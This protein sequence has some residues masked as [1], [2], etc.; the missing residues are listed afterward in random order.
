MNVPFPSIDWG[1]LSS[2]LVPALLFS[3]RAADLSLATLRTLAVIRGRSGLAW[4][5]GF[6]ESVFFLLGAAGLLATL[7]NPLNLLAYGAGFA[8]GNVIGLSLEGRLLPSHAL[9]RIYSPAQ[10]QAIAEA[11]RREGW[12][13]TETFGRGLEGSVELILCF[14]PK[15][16][17]NRLRDRVVLLDPQAVITLQNVRSLLGGWRP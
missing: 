15:R 10:G 9:V 8:T 7:T 6:T 16:D 11:L 2:G 3:L 17:A 13:V 14:A 12:G 5:L 4:M 1:S